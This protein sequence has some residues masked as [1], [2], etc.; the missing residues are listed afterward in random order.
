MSIAKRKNSLW[1]V[2]IFFTTLW[3]ENVFKYSLVY[4]LVLF[5][6]KWEVPLLCPSSQKYKHC[7][8]W[9]MVGG[10]KVEGCLWSNLA[11]EGSLK[12]AL[13]N[14]QKDWLEDLWKSCSTDHLKKLAS[15]RSLKFTILL[16][17]HHESHPWC[18]QIYEVSYSKPEFSSISS[19][20]G[21][22]YDSGHFIYNHSICLITDTQT[23]LV[24][25]NVWL[26]STHARCT[27]MSMGK[28]RLGQLLG[29]FL[30]DPGAPIGT[31]RGCL[32]FLWLVR[33]TAIS[34]LNSSHEHQ[35]SHCCVA[36]CENI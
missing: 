18:S 28:L 13:Q 10:F 34:Q 17:G 22:S 30:P 20:V 24:G 36:L 31:L 6:G 3:L 9:F 5:G 26:L 7:I 21:H 4:P 19:M 25:N 15:G 1:F 23:N 8:T 29:G 2:V 32:F 33:L 35:F 12:V 27:T 16:Q 11:S 14:P